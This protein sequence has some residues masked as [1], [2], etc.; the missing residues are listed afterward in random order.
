MLQTKGPALMARRTQRTPPPFSGDEHCRFCGE[1][2]HGQPWGT[3][4]ALCGGSWTHFT[5]LAESCQPKVVS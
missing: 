1:L 3:M 4:V 2:L 5:C